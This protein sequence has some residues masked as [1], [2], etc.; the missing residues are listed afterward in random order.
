MVDLITALGLAITIEGIAYALFP[1]GM[2]KMMAQV[3]TLPSANIRVAGL[4]AAA[5]GIFT[6]WLVRG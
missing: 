3:M 5:A 6:L 1:D 4:A 2:K